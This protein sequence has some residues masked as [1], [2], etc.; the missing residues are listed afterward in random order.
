MTPLGTFN[1]PAHRGVP[2]ALLGGKDLWSVPPWQ[3]A[4]AGILGR[5]DASA[6]C[7]QVTCLYHGA[8]WC[9]RGA[10]GAAAAP[11]P[12]EAPGEERRDW[13]L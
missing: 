8:N 2:K 1:R 7:S 13:F 4:T 5:F 3:H 6:E 9:G 11:L 10:G 12:E